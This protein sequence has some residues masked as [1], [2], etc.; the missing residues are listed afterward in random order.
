[1]TFVRNCAIFAQNRAIPCITSWEW[2]FVRNIEMFQFETTAS[3]TDLQVA[4]N[5]DTA[6]YNE[7]SVVSSGIRYFRNRDISLTMIRRTSEDGYEI[8]FLTHF[9]RTLSCPTSV[10]ITS[11]KS[12]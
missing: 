8:I 12:S 10:K 9:F 7:K 5:T 11:V 6:A 3:N 4:T 2:V 1:M